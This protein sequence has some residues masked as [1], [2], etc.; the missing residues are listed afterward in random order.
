MSTS[1]T[2]HAFRGLV[3]SLDAGTI[4]IGVT[5]SNY[6]LRLAVNEPVDVSVG[7]R[8]M[9]AISAIGLRVHVATAGG[10]FIE[11]TSGEPRIVAGRVESIDTDAG[12]IV[13]QSVVPICVRLETPEE[14]ASLR[15]GDLVNF[16]VR[17]GATW[18]A[19]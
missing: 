6:H 17:S 5:G 16:H 3:E 1:S 7:E 12:A 10:L 9:G 14:A 2:R 19:S 8:V 13:V 18:Q 11:P 4:V 15:E